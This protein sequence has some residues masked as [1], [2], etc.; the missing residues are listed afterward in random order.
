MRRI[1]A[2]SLA[3]LILGVPA[4]SAA[5]PQTCA[6]R[7]LVFSAFPGEIDHL[8]TSATISKTEVLDGRAFYVGKLQGNDVALALT[9]I[10]L[11]NAKQ[12]AD[13]AFDHFRCGTEP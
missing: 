11:V 3:L 9:G 4:A 8:L 1:A 2:I 12:A 7:L 5:A 6:P 10:G 13:S